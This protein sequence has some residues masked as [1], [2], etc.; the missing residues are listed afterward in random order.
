MYTGTFL[1]SV[2][3]IAASIKYRRK[4][5]HKPL[6]FMALLI[7]ALLAG[8]RDFSI[9]NDVMLYGNYWF[10]RAT[11]YNSLVEYLKKALEHSIDS[12][13]ASINYLCSLISK[14]AHFFY[15][16]YA[17]LQMIVL[18]FAIKDYNKMISVPFAFFVYFFTYYNSSL[19]ILRQIMAILLVLL[20][21]RFVFEKKPQK[22]FVCILFAM[23]FHV[24]AIVG[25]VLYPLN[26]A[27][28]TD[29]KK[30]WRFAVIAGSVALVGVYEYILVA[31][32]RM[33][34]TSFNRYTHYLA[35]DQGGGRYIRLAFW[36]F[37]CILYYLNRNR[38]KKIAPQHELIGFCLFFSLV[39]SFINFFSG[40]WM[41]RIIYYFDCISVFSIPLIAKTIKVKG[42]F[43]KLKANYMLIGLFIYVYWLIVYVV[44]NGAATFPYQFMKF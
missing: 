43:G 4:I 9:G 5:I 35:D 8:L 30:F 41:I 27:I 12:G 39:A 16:I 32:S 42:G 33:G 19:N 34:I 23:S 44:R 6:V 26:W 21:Y 24:S 36:T 14:D 7:P 31:I 25:S 1:I 20:S 38:I 22:F 28:H 29:F 37:F 2:A 13:Y 18:Y 17:L 3:F 40:A 11:N 15:F 10:E